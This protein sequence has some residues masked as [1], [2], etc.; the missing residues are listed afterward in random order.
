MAP[1]YDNNVALI[2][3]GYPKDVER[4]SDRLI[5]F[6]LEFLQKCPKARRM[7]ADLKIPTVT[8]KM[9]ED[10]MNTVPVSV[11]RDYIR[12]FILSGQRQIGLAVQPPIQR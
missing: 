7:Y 11:D 10:A 9:L 5:A 3:R 1:N 4:R 8:E 6:L 12:R 2:S